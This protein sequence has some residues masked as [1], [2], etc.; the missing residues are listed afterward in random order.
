MREQ[1]NIFGNIDWLTVGLYL[2]LVIFGC[3]NIY[4]AKFDENH[5]SLFDFT[6]QYGKQIIWVAAAIV[7]ALV[8]MLIDAK[9][10][11]AF[12][13]PVY[14]ICVLLLI[15]V[16]FTGKQVMGHRSWFQIGSFALQPSEF[17]K[18]A[19]NL[20]IAKYLSTL[21]V[22]FR[23]LR[24]K[25]ILFAII[26]LP[27]ILIIFQGDA[28]SSLIYAGFIL[29]L[30]RFGLSGNILIIGL[31]S[32]VLFC[33]AL[34]VNK[35][36]IVGLLAAI[37]GFF[38]YAY[39][40]DKKAIIVIS[41][42]LIVAASF[43]FT[44]NFA[45]DNVLKPHQKERINVLF[46]KNTDLKGAGFNVNQSKIAIGSG[47]FWGKG[48]LMGTQTKY[49]FVP[50]QSTDFIFCTIGEE[51]GF[52]GS[53]VIVCLFIGLFVRL[54]YLAERQRSTFARIYGYGV[55]CILFMHFLINVGMTMGIAPVI[56]IPLPF[57]SYGGSSL[58][59]FTI[60]LFIFVKQDSYRL[61]LL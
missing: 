19:V 22:D 23:K 56:G 20:V 49:D 30:Y 12:A 41:G 46:G 4:A 24:T 52:V 60:L 17:A 33:L 7:I 47:G 45:F 42:L 25:L 31:V 11:V 3:M 57:F 6:Q 48:Y 39:N 35:F 10:F 26:I 8:I 28:G 50:E 59:S 1:K 37:G 58:W 38:I 51:W 21:N 9:F 27:V 29:L 2:V 54:A 5:R 55:A 53:T 40:R 18:F 36:V 16:I 14:G 43:V 61:Q 13:Y 34:L 15:A 32:I 44:V